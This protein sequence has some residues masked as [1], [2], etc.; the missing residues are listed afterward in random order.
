MN[1]MCQ[2][3]LPL[4]GSANLYIIRSVAKGFPFSSLRMLSVE[5]M[6]EIVVLKLFNSKQQLLCLPMNSWN[7]TD[8]QTPPKSFFGPF[9]C[10]SCSFCTLKYQDCKSD[11]DLFCNKALKASFF[12]W[13]TSL[14]SWIHQSILFTLPA[15]LSTADE[16]IVVWNNDHYSIS[17]SSE[18]PEIYQNF[19][20]MQKVY[21]F[22]AFLSA[23]TSHIIL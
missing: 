9:Y 2:W 3:M 4:L 12:A 11:N 16:I 21:C 14:T 17:M 18:T 8:D 6:M 22:L 7:P 5:F 13:I 23:R 15:R 19:V 1:R 20:A 10:L